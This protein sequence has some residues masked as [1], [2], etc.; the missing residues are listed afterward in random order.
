MIFKGFKFGILL[1]FAV[2]PV[3][4]YLFQTAVSSGLQS[5]LTGVFGVVLADGL[6]IAMAVFGLGAVIRKNLRMQSIFQGFGGTVVVLF[7]LSTLLGAFGY[8]LLPSLNLQTTGIENMFVKTL[9]LT[10]SNPMTILFWTGVF[11]AKIA[12]ENLNQQDMLQFG[13]GAVLSTL[14]FL[15]GI[16]LLGSTISVFLNQNLLRIFNIAVGIILM[17]FG[18]RIL[19]TALQNKQKITE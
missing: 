15:G 11:S 5:A 9:L 7:G 19:R 3:C 17:G 8:S 1:Q 2:G 4:L 13:L 18:T 16:S 14:I 12:E 10:L 6:Y